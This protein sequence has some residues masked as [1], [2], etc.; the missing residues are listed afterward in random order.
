MYA[1]LWNERLGP[2]EDDN[3]YAGTRGGL[4]KSVDGGTT[5]KQL[6]NG[7]TRRSGADQCR[8]RCERSTAAVCDIVD[9]GK[10][11]YAT[12]KGLGVYRSDDAGASWRK[13]TDDPR[14]AMKIGGGDLPVPGGRSEESRHGV[15][16]QHR[17]LPLDGRRKD[18]DQPA[19]RAGRRRLPEHVDQS[20]GSENPAAGERSGRGR[21]RERR[22]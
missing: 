3:E 1:S 15:Q 9:H 5:W 6:T 13:I 18:V 21:Q 20:A 12:G 2:W 16:H 11:G 22:R 4:F 8:R 17:D 10:G 19:R 14:P 7:L